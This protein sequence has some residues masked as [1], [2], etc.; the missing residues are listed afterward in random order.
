MRRVR[1]TVTGASRTTLAV[2]LI[3]VM[4]LV[5]GLIGAS[6]LALNGFQGAKR[7]LGTAQ[8]GLSY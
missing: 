8:L 1:P 3:L 4:L 6:P 7:P 2:T 5:V